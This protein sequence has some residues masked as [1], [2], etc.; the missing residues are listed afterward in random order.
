MV[1]MGKVVV[2]LIW[3]ENKCIDKVAFLQSE[4][5]DLKKRFPKQQNTEHSL[6]RD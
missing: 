3:V 6:I 4:V 2:I 1:V 5:I